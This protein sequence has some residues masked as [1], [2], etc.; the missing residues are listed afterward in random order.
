MKL[1]DVTPHRSRLL[2][3]MLTESDLMEYYGLVEER[4]MEEKEYRDI[5]RFPQVWFNIIFNVLK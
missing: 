1:L 3:Y 2:H 5:F 4:F